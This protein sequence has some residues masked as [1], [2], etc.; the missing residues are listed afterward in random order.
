MR[1]LRNAIGSLDLFA[2]KLWRVISQTVVRKT[3]RL[4]RRWLCHRGNYRG[5]AGPT[6]GV[7]A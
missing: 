2:G 4:A 7:L 1:V 5:F 3:D 6:A